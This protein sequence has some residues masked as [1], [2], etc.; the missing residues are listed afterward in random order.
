MGAPY[1]KNIKFLENALHSQFLLLNQI[2]QIPRASTTQG[3]SVATGNEFVSKGKMRGTV[4]QML[5]FSGLTPIDQKLTLMVS[6]AWVV[7][8]LDAGHRCEEV[9][10]RVCIKATLVLSFD[11]DRTAD[12]V[13]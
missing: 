9:E 6:W 4:N 2:S 7:R 5:L 8:K 1:E 13:W 3:H 11:D 12:R 10:E